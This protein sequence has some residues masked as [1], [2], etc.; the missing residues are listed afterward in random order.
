[1]AYSGVPAFATE[2]SPTTIAPTDSVTIRDTA[3]PFPAANWATSLNVDAMTSGVEFDALGFVD[4]FG[5]GLTTDPSRGRDRA[6]IL[7]VAQAGWSLTDV[8]VNGLN[9]LTFTLTRVAG[10]ETATRVLIAHASG[11]GSSI[12]ITINGSAPI[13]VPTTIGQSPASIRDA[14]NTAINAAAVAG[15]TSH[16]TGAIVAS[17]TN[18]VTLL[19]PLTSVSVSANAM[20]HH[21]RARVRFAYPDSGFASFPYVAPLQY[22][23]AAP[24]PPVITTLTLPSVRQGVAYSQPITASGGTTP[25][26]WA[27]APGS[28]PL[29][30][31]LALSPTGTPSATLSGTPTT[32]GLYQFT[33]RVTDGVGATDDQVY[34]M[35][36]YTLAVTIDNAGGREVSGVAPV[37]DGAYRVRFTDAAGPIFYS[38]VQGQA[39]RVSVVSGAFECSS[40]PSE[41]GTFDLHL[42]SLADG[43]TVVVP[44]AV[45]VRPANYWSS[46]YDLRALFPD[47]V[48]TGARG[49][50]EEG[51]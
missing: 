10:L 3:T 13:I 27:L 32:P 35:A 21:P 40:P 33:V 7:G 36:V 48:A 5:P 43:S 23:I 37:V 25:Y 39:D 8:V 6:V 20:V 14:L 17:A 2:A 12:T 9:D 46:A 15:I 51:S 19:G 22:F 50:G 16:R 26:S 11:D 30:P 4:S 41:A 49:M 29:P 38:G 42:T 45:I 47:K 18:A 34:L 1:M 28:D 44:E 24:T 31:G